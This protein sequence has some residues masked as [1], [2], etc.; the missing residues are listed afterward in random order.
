MLFTPETLD[1]INQEVVKAGHTLLKKSPNAGPTKERGT[2]DASED[3]KLQGRCDSFVVETDVHY[4][5]D[6]SLLYDAVRKAIGASAALAQHHRLKG[7]RQYQHSIRTFKSQYRHVQKLKHSSSKNDAQKASQHLKIQAAHLR[8]IDMGE[9]WLE[10]SGKARQEA[11]SLGAMAHETRLSEQYHGY[12]RIL[13]DQIRRRVI[14]G[15]KIP[16]KEKIFSLF[17]PH[18]EWISKGKAGVPVELGLR[19][20][21]MEDQHRFLLHHKVME[22]ET[23]DKIAVEMVT[24]SQKRF[25]QL[26]IA[27]FDKGFHSPQ[28]Q[29][30][31]KELLELSVLPK[32]GRLSEADK[33]RE[34]SKEFKMLRHQHSAVES[35]INAL[36][37]HG[38]DMC[39]DHGIDGFKRYVALAVVARNIHRLGSLIRNQQREKTRRKR[40]PYKKAA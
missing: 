19:V 34:G 38:L 39:P 26:A 15:E 4:P 5:T 40:R 17:E 32:K 21:V 24:E 33:Q 37:Q 31:L 27:S 11:A 7:W 8:Y 29:K 3:E 10:K 28:N 1:Q 6:I 30:S 20:C 12:A 16:H 13:I 18:T 35:A 22:K 2:N 25:S 36:E 14:L 9:A 23:D